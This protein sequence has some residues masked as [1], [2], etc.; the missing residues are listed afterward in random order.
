MHRSPPGKGLNRL[1]NHSREAGKVPLKST[2][3]EVARPDVRNRKRNGDF[4]GFF[5]LKRRLPCFCVP[6]CMSSLGGQVLEGCEGRVAGGRRGH[7]L[8]FAR[9][10]GGGAHAA[11]AAVQQ[12]RRVT[13]AEV[14]QVGHV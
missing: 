10:A 3:S 11:Q 7:S 9:G 14:G 13:G 5:F 1:Q 6:W 4:C 12:V 8:H 2:P